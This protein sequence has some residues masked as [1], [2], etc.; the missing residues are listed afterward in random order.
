MNYLGIVYG[1]KGFNYYVYGKKEPNHWGAVNFPDLRIG[2]PYLIKEK[3][4]LSDVIL[5]GKDIK[6]EVRIDE[7]KIHYGVKEYKGKRYIICVNVEPEELGVEMK[8]PEGVKKMKVISEN[9]TVEVKDGKFFDKFLPYEVHIYTDD[10]NFQ[11]VV[12]L[13]KVEE[14]IKKEGGWYSYQY[15]K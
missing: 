13:K 4:S 6:Q 15:K 12:D 1:A 7:K 9:R 5:L 3:K 14:E 8:V 10:L 11:D 2:M